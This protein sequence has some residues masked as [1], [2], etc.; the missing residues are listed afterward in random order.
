[1][2]F[3]LDPNQSPTVASKGFRPEKKSLQGFVNNV[4]TSGV[5]LAKGIGESAINVLNPDLEKNTLVNLGKT[6]YDTGGAIG[7]AITGTKVPENNKFKQ[8]A[9]F[10]KT[11]YG[12]L[13]NIGNTL[14]NDPVGAAMDVSMLAGGAGGLLKAGGLEGAANVAGKVSEF[15]NPLNAVTKPLGMARKAISPMAADASKTLDAAGEN[16]LT[17]GMGNPMEL[18]KVKAVSPVPMSELFNK[19]NTYERTPEA[20]QAAIDSAGAK[21]DE[22]TKAASQNGSKVDVLKVLDEYNQQIKKLTSEAPT[23]DAAAQQLAELSRRKD[24]FIKA[25]GGS[26]STPLNVDV[27]QVKDIKKSFQGDMPK[28]AFAAPQGDLNK[29]GGTKLAYKALIKGIEEAA[30]GTKSLGREQS[31]LIK[32]KDI[33]EKQVARND[34]KMNLSPLRWIAPGAGAKIAGAPGAIAATIM[35]NFF[36]SPEALK[37]ESKIMKGGSKLLKKTPKMP[38]TNIFKNAANISKAGYATNP[39]RNQ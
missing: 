36:N 24:M 8:I 6:I 12:G 34:A 1:M 30:P 18:K 14:Y 29:A 27:G 26:D 5:N 10:Y 17:R 39:K 3:R 15:T 7:N 13:E 37:W 4:G 22:L 35:E 19:Y 11:R 2:P 32:L 23:S 16:A 31:A 21:I 9:D 25:I 33:A 28:N 20:F 38:K